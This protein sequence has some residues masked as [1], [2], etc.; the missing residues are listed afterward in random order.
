MTIYAP[1]FYKTPPANFKPKRR[2]ISALTNA[3]NAE[4]TTTE[5]HEY[6]VGQLVRMHVSKNYGMTLEGVG[7]TVLTVPSTTT[8]TINTDTRDLES[9]V[10]PTAPPAF[11]QAHVVPITGIEDNV[12]TRGN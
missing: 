1:S 2:E 8:F 10:I 3:E 9:F 12:A 6:E 5:D 4:V 11:T 7:A